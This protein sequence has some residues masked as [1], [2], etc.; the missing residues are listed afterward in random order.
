MLRIVLNILI[1]DDEEFNN[2]VEIVKK[3][4]KLEDEN[5]IYKVLPTIDKLL[6]HRKNSQRYRNI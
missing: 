4:A 5:L 2:Y 6:N 3:Y 1:L